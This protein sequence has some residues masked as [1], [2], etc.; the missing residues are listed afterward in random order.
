MEFGSLRMRF[1]C[2][3]KPSRGKVTRIRTPLRFKPIYLLCIL[4]ALRDINGATPSQATRTCI[5]IRRGE[6]E[7]DAGA[8]EELGSIQPVGLRE[9]VVAQRAHGQANSKAL[10]P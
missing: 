8:C 6:P 1:R 5:R 7:P 9:D 3:R 4:F 2:N 10:H